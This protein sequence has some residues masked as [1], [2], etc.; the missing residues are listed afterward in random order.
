[1]IRIGTIYRI[2]NTC[3]VEVREIDPYRT[4]EKTVN[5]VFIMHSC[6]YGALVSIRKKSGLYT[7]NI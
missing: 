7:A 6:C 4:H 2:Q 1:M 3:N 5:F